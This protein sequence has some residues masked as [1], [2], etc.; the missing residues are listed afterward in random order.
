MS[1]TLL[2]AQIEDFISGGGGG[3]GGGGWSRPD[4]QNTVWTFFLLFLVLSLFYSLQRASNGFITEK[5]ILSKDQRGSNIFQ[6]GS[7][8]FHAG[9]NYNFY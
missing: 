8:F 9:P 1:H 7:N 5:N 3:V 2:H 6:G 4:G